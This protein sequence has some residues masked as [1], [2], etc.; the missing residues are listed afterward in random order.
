METSPNRTIFKVDVEHSEQRLDNYLIRELKGTPKSLLYKLIRKSKIKVNNKKSQPSYKLVSGDEILVLAQAKSDRKNSL[1]SSEGSFAW[2]EE[3]VLFEN[4][5][6]ILFNKPP[7]LAV[8][9]GTGDFQG[10]IEMFRIQRPQLKAMDLVHRLDKLT[11]GCV[12][13]AKKRSSLRHYHEIF[14]KRHVTKDYLAIVHGR[15]SLGDYKIE[16]SLNRTKQLGITRSIIASTGKP[17]ITNVRLIDRN[18]RYS[19]LHVQLET[20][21][22]HQIRAHLNHLDFPIVGDPIYIGR[23]LPTKSKKE[24]GYA[25]MYL[26][27]KSLSFEDHEALGI[28]S[29]LTAP[30]T[31]DFINFIGSEDFKD[32][33]QI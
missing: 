23:R 15:W 17:S 5:D 1:A 18:R 24:K 29:Q 19:L 26:H 12:L 3:H 8:H 4:Q 6:V 22:L 16:L 31:S 20:G 32:P 10:L 28:A 13:I 30:L 33:Y 9:S 21:R 27:A 14:R 25:R 11:S 2:L 7:G